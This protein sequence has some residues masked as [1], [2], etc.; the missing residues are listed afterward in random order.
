MIVSKWA[1]G[2]GMQEGQT[3]RVERSAVSTNTASGYFTFQIM[4]EHL[5]D[6]ASYPESWPLQILV[7]LR[8]LE[9]QDLSGLTERLT[10]MEKRQVP[11]QD[12]V[13]AS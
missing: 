10:L 6:P 12:L 5:T 1:R 3:L 8:L 11:G 9:E 13:A 4:A 2:R 7:H